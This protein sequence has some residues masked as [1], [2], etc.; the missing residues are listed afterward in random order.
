MTVVGVFVIAVIG[1]IMNLIGLAS[2]PQMIVKGAV[3]IFAVILKS[4]SSK[5]QE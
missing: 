3:I 4:V 2:Y 1:N 5:N